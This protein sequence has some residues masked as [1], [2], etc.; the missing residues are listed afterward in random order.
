MN[1]TDLAEY[2]VT[3]SNALVEAAYHLS[4]AEQR[5]VLMA[6]AQTDSRNPSAEAHTF[7]VRATD[8]AELFQVDLATA[9]E[10][11]A[12][13]AHRLYERSMTKITRPDEKTEIVE[14]VRWIDRRLVK[15]EQR[16]VTELEVSWSRHIQPYLTVL[17]DKFTSYELRQV[18]R[19]QSPYA[20]RLYEWL[21]QWLGT[22][23]EVHMTLEEFRTR[24]DLGKKYPR[25]TDLRKFV[26]QPSVDSINLHTN[27]DVDW[28]PIRTKRKVTRLLFVAAERRQGSLD[29]APGKG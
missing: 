12:D 20:I 26:L 1:A 10:A 29:L 14:D 15:K 17:R 7:R 9:Y 6:I 25:F 13:A 22:T 16:Y 2:K 28:E 24:L 4:L 27:L 3:K 8:Y 5:L 21:V 23:G 19:L 18:I 11:L